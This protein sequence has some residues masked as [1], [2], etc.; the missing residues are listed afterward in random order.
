MTD[1][2]YE[3]TSKPRHVPFNMPDLSDHGSGPGTRCLSIKA[4]HDD[5]DDDS[6]ERFNNCDIDIIY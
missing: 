2:A 1:L 3:D 5:D 4:Q 6:K